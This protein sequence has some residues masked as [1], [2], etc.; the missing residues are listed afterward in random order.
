MWEYLLDKIFTR[1]CAD[2]G[3]SMINTPPLGKATTNGKDRKQF[4]SRNLKQIFELIQK[5]QLKS[6]KI[7]AKFLLHD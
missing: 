2:N 4:F 1:M 3:S 6:K 7:E 5:I